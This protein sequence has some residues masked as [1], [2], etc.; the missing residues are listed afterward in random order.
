MAKQKTMEGEGSKVCE[1]HEIIKGTLGTWVQITLWLD[2][3]QK[4]CKL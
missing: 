2:E 4:T 3:S 1:R